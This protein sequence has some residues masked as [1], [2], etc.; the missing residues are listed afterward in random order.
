MAIRIDDAINGMHSHIQ[1]IWKEDL[2][3][4]KRGPLTMSLD[5]LNSALLRRAEERDRAI[6]LME[7]ANI[8]VGIADAMRKKAED[9]MKALWECGPSDVGFWRV[10]YPRYK[11][12]CE[13]L[14]KWIELQ[15]RK[16]NEAAR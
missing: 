2:A 12:F 5:W 7:E 16:R 13:A 3:S 11:S 15:K 4:N 9:R 10:A 6:R 14:D 8:A 1:R